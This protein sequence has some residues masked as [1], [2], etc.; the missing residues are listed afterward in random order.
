MLFEL[1]MV[2]VTPV[3]RVG[4]GSAT[5]AGIEHGDDLALYVARAILGWRHQCD[6]R[7]ETPDQDQPGAQ[8]HRFV[9][10]FPRGAPTGAT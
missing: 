9:L 2:S 7:D 4:E 6:V 5:R 1:G 8:G 10:S 3:A